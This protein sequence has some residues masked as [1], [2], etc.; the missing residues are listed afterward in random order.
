M[1]SKWEKTQ[2][3]WLERFINVILNLI[4]MELKNHPT[5]KQQLIEH[6]FLEP[7]D[8]RSN[9]YIDSN[10]WL[11]LKLLEGFCSYIHQ[12]KWY[13]YI[14]LFHY[15]LN[16]KFA[17]FNYSVWVFEVWAATASNTLP[18]LEFETNFHFVFWSFW[19]SLYK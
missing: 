12:N 5:E 15:L 17:I 11:Y 10:K 7:N 2:N 9:S 16:L 14:T 1:I 3:N 6:L 8:T 18:K 13:L 19:G 4:K